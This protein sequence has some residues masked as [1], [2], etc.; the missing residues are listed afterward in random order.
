MCSGGA[1]VALGVWAGVEAKE[2]NQS[3]PRSEL[4]PQ[5]T[6]Q[7]LEV[8]VELVWMLSLLLLSEFWWSWEGTAAPQPSPKPL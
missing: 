3:I 6:S 4:L 2:G 8:V 5:K 7:H 1:H